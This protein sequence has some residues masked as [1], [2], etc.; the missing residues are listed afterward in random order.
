MV[1]GSVVN[2]LET[3]SEQGCGIDEKIAHDCVLTDRT[4]PLARFRYCMVS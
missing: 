4:M 2:T 3:G 1:M